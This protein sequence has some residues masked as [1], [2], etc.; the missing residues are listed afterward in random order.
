MLK[1]LT[2]C[3]PA[4]AVIGGEVSTGTGEV[5][6]GTGD[7]IVDGV[8]VDLLLDGISNIVVSCLVAS[9]L[10]ARLRLGVFFFSGDAKHLP[11]IILGLIFLSQRGKCLLQ[12]LEEGFKP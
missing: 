2:N 9:L 10:F 12:T 11:K 4:N 5:S 8:V 7:K 6:K 1:S 3:S